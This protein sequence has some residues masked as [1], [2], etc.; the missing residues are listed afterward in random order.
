MAELS[1][2]SNDEFFKSAFVRLDFA[3]DYLDQMLPPDVHKEL[4]FAVLERVNGA[5]VDND[6]QESL[7]DVV[8]Q[9]Q[10]NQVPKDIWISFIFEHKS[11]P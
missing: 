3:R 5:I 2:K 10:L 9:S 7:T 6:L 11:S 1:S 8:Y 4:Y